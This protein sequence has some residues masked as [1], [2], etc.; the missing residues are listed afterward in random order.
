MHSIMI[1]MDWSTTYWHNLA[2]PAR[3]EAINI[4]LADLDLSDAWMGLKYAKVKSFRQKRRRVG[5]N[6]ARPPH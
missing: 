2:I 4:C 1:A 3:L 5:N 6:R